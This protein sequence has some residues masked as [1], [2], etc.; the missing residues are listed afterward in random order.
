VAAGKNTLEQG[1]RL[2]KKART[3]AE[4]VRR[5]LR[6]LGDQDETVALSIRFRR[7]RARFERGLENDEA[8]DTFGELTLATHELNLLLSEV[9]LPNPS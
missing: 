7:M 4:R 5:L 9:F 6:R 8:I 3:R 1:L 2:I